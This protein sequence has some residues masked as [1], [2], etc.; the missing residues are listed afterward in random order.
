MDLVA[1]DRAGLRGRRHRHPRR[2]EAPRDAGL[3]G[4]EP[5]DPRV[6]RHVRDRAAWIRLGLRAAGGGKRA[7]AAAFAT[8]ATPT[9]CGS[10]RPRCRRMAASDVSGS[11][12]T[13]A[14]PVRGTLAALRPAGDRRGRHAGRGRRAALRLADHGPA[15][16]RFER[17]VAA[18]VGRRHAVAV[19]SGTAALHAATFAAGIGP[20][21]E[22]VVAGA[23]LCGVRQRRAATRA[24]R[25]SSPT[26]DATRSA[27]TPPTSR[28][29]SRRGRAPSWP[30]T[31]PASP[32][33]RRARR[34][35]ARPRL[36]ADRG[37]RARA[38]RRVPR[39]AASARSPT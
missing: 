32:R 11:R 35:R 38:G 29:R 22:V 28:P 37:R 30:W 13:A 6:R 31:T 25:R 36:R 18:A 16:R 27:W 8:R 20:G 4:R 21:D 33:T 39:P 19:S 3:R 7:G 9:T 1:G 34:H 12:S 17:A 15:G 14:R 2:R 5:P 26:C 23:H 10:R 24:G